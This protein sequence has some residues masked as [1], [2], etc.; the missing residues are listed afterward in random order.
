M[1]N[2]THSPK[3]KSWHLDRSAIVYVRQSTPQ[4][5]SEHQE[6]TA[7]LWDAVNGRELLTLK[8]N[9]G[10]I[11]TVALTPD[12]RQLV[13]GSDDGTVQIWEAATPAQTALWTRQHQEMERRRAAWERP[14]PDASSFIQDWLVLAPLAVEDRAKAL[15]QEQVRG[16][17]RLQ[18]QAGKQ[19]QVGG[20]EFAWKAHHA[21]EPVLDFYRLVGKQSRDSIAYA[22]CYVISAAERNDLLLQVSSE[23]RAKV[24]LNGQEVYRY[25]GPRGLWDVDPVGPITLRKGT[26]VLIL[27]VPNRGAWLGCARFVDQEGNPV[28]GLQVRLTPE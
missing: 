17:A 24:Y 2:P 19:V 20:Q 1:T 14:V 26:N 18:P 13:T 3:I 15:E 22:M 16:E 25:S 21:E 6:S 5:V 28:H 11:R 8:G 27:K 4:Q 9:T 12:G 23:G 7:R 10:P